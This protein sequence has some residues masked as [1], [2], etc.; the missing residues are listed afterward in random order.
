VGQAGLRRAQERNPWDRT[1]DRFAG[2]LV[3]SIADMLSDARAGIL[4]DPDA[5]EEVLPE[6]AITAQPR[7]QFL[8]TLRDIRVEQRRDFAQ[9]TNR[10]LDLTRQGLAV[11]DIERPSVVQCDAETNRTSENVIPRQPVD[12]YG[13][14]LG[15]H[16]VTLAHHLHDAAQYAVRI[17]HSFR[18]PGLPEVNSSFAT[19]SGLTALA[20]DS[21]ASVGVVAT[22]ASK[23]VARRSGSPRTMTTSASFGVYARSAA[24]Y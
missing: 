1:A 7:D 5:A 10:L 12:E 23:N 16:G 22:S 21:T 6:R 14:L 2:K 24:A 4:Q 3:E 18:H 13:S 8:V 17:D 19:V 11:I 15:E 20:A 9:V